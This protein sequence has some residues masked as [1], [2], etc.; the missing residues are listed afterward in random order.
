M[1]RGNLRTRDWCRCRR[2]RWTSRENTVSSY[3]CLSLAT[4]QTQRGSPESSQLLSQDREHQRHN[5]HLRRQAVHQYSWNRVRF[6]QALS[7][8]NP[9]GNSV[10]RS[11]EIPANFRIGL[12]ITYLSSQGR[13]RRL[14]QWL[15]ILRE[16]LPGPEKMSPGERSTC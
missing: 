1:L 10:T 6:L 15:W 11:H 7:H 9:D 5:D 3:P 8:T 4:E 14:L 2:K 13:S 12:Q 16:R